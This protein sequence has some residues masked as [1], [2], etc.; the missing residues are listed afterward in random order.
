M[1]CA[2]S[3]RGVMLHGTMWSCRNIYAESCSEEADRRVLSADPDQFLDLFALFLV[4]GCVEPVLFVVASVSAGYEVCV[5]VRFFQYRDTVQCVLR[6]VEI[7]GT[8]IELLNV[9]LGKL[10]FLNRHRSV[11]PAPSSSVILVKP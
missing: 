6:C 8:W 4:E 7:E 2:S 10:L 11:S 3:S 9:F 5:P 1:S